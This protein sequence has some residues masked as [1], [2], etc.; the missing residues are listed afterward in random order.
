MK[1]VSMGKKNKI[2]ALNIKVCVKL[3]EDTHKR[4][5]LDLDGSHGWHTSWISVIPN[6]ELNVWK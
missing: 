6:K 4:Q 3:H 1:Q 2:S 5:T